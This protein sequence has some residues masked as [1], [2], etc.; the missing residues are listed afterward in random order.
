[1][2]PL[3]GASDLVEALT[4]QGRRVVVASSS[5]AE[6]VD[7]LLDLVDMRANSPPSSPGPTTRPASPR[8]TW[9][10]LAVARAGGGKAIVVG[11]AVW[12][13]LAAESAEVPCI[14]LR[15]GGIGAE[16]L[17]LRGA[18]WVLRRPARPAGAASD[19]AS[20]LAL[21]AGAV[22][23]PPPGT[24]RLQQACAR[25]VAWRASATSRASVFSGVGGRSR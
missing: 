1:M 24:G 12:D 18:S 9:S 17:A 25:W 4:D 20:P 23:T 11:D 15:S 8:P 16:R 3:D 10:R 22:R 2:R 5:E 13:A 7:E 19:R 6:L 21:S 14:G